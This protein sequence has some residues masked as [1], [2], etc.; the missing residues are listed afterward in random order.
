MGK[1]HLRTSSFGLMDRAR[2]LTAA[3]L[4]DAP[5]VQ[6]EGALTHEEIFRS[7]EKMLVDVCLGESVFPLATA[8]QR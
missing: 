6:I 2:V 3:W 4:A 1:G 7:Q 8:S 5:S